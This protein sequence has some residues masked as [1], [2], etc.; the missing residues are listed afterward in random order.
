MHAG[1]VHAINTRSDAKNWWRT[2]NIDIHISRLAYFIQQIYAKCDYFYL[3]RCCMH[4]YQGFSIR[5][6]RANRGSLTE[7]VWFFRTRKYNNTCGSL[8]K[9]VATFCGSCGF[10]CTSPFISQLKLIVSLFS[11]KLRYAEDQLAPWYCSR[12]PFSRNFRQNRTVWLLY[13]DFTV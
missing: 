13:S 6:S 11:D 10:L 4:L 12:N 9:R 8:V 7:N 3:K 1:S 2:Q 5:G